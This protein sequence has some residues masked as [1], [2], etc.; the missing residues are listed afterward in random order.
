MFVCFRPRLVDSI[1]LFMFLVKTVILVW[2]RTVGRNLSFFYKGILIACSVLT[3]LCG[4]LT[5]ENNFTA[6]PL[7]RAIC[8]FICLIDSVKLFMF[9][10]RTVSAVSPFSLIHAW[11]R[12]NVCFFF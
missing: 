12:R 1:N 3:T 2:A 8:L 5:R 6:N 11:A 10:V 9:P 4:T 7:F